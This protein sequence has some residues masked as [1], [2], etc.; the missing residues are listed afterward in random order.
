MIIGFDGSRAFLKDKTG[1]ENYS[2]QL[3]KHLLKI[4]QKNNYIIYT[5][6]CP[7]GH[8]FVKDAQNAVVREI[9]LPRLW[10]QLGLA[11]HTLID[12]LDLLF[13]PAH[14]LPIFRKPGLKTV[15]TVH[16]LGA[17]YLPKMHLI[18][19]RLYLKIMTYY[20]LKSATKL[21][22]VSQATKDDIC[23]KVR[24]NGKK[25]AVIYEGYDEKLFKEVK[26]DL[27]IRE[28]K[29]FNIAPRSYFLFVGTI[30]PRK[31][32]ISI[33]QSY[34]EFLKQSDQII[35]NLNLPELVLVG[36]KG[37]LSDDSYNLAKKLGI[38]DMVKFL[39]RIEDKYLPSLYSG[40]IALVFPS[41]FEGF[42]L[43]IL[44]AQSCN[45]PVIT[46]NISSMPEVAGKGAILVNPYQAREVTKAMIDIYTDD[47]LRDRLI[48][49]GSE[50]IKRFSWEKCAKETLAMFNSLKS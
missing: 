37:W 49:K 45:C 36:A 2:Y 41:Y 19:Q 34:N 5:K 39:G 8:D 9:N 46:S 22:A 3:L 32:I 30:Q 25:I 48:S 17:E 33:I 21:I 11:W 28:L 42:G 24:I 15:M 44:E 18:K 27:L 4:D 6:K 40:A 47:I 10:T 14:T 7:I 31:N 1:T 35:K 29:K 20:Q 50:N 43:P 26:N 38:E 12:K 16:D 13:I 23:K